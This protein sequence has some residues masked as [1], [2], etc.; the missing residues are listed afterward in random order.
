MKTR[1]ALLIFFLTIYC[2]LPSQ[3][4]SLTQTIKGKVI[5]ADSKEML[6]GIVVTLIGIN[7]KVVTDSI[8]DF[9]ISN[10]PIGILTIEVTGVNYETKLIPGIIVTSGKEIFLEI[11]LNEKIRTLN[12]V[13]IHSE[14]RQNQAANEFASA[15]SRSFSMEESKR[16]PI[17]GFDPGRI[18]QNFAGVSLTE[19]NSNAVIIRGNSPK[20]IAWRIEGVEIPNPNHFGNTGAGGGNIS[21]LSSSMLGKSDFYTGA[22]PPEFGNAL[23]G[24]FD[25]KLRKGNPD[26]KEHS[27]MVG[28]L[29][30]EAASEGPLKK[31]AHSSYLVNFRY[32]TFALLKDVAQIDGVTPDYQDMSFKLFFPAKKGG[33]LSIFGLGGL[34]KQLRE[35]ERFA[36]FFT[37]LFT[38]F[39]VEEKGSVGIAG[40]SHQLFLTKNSY[41]Q[42][43]IAV[44]TDNYRNNTDTLNYRNNYSREAVGKTKFGSINYKFSSTYN[45][46]INSHHTIRSGIIVTRL[47][48]NFTDEQYRPGINSWQYIFD[49]KGHSTFYEGYLQWKWRMG[50]R[51][52]LIQGVHYSI[53]VLNKASSLEPRVSLTYR[54]IRNQ[55]FILAAGLH[56]RPEHLST[57]F[58]GYLKND[59]A[60]ETKFHDLELTKAAHVVLSYQKTFKNFTCKLET[61]YQHLFNVPVEKDTASFFSTINALSIYDL[62]DTDSSLIS[63]G[64]GEN[65]GIDLTIEKPFTKDWH[66]LLTASLLRSTF[67][68][69]S[70]KNFHTKFDRGFQL[71]GLAGKE[72]KVGKNDNRKIAANG[73]V[74]IA[75]GLRESPIDHR[76][77]ELSN[78]IVYEYDKYY[79]QQTRPYSRIDL[80]IS[81]KINR[82]RSTHIIMLDIQNILNHENIVRTSYNFRAKRTQVEHS[83]GL[84][85]LFN[86]RIEF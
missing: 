45:K 34:N 82:S 3:T 12:E 61:Y 6:S 14:N 53:L 70:N 86:Y 48:Y 46:K 38:L 9:R 66:F 10:V 83:L 11:G 84:F 64:K 8:G 18:V 43:T 27:I 49:A 24:V 20:N 81:Y 23:S 80:G 25:L 16:Y 72:W 7:I 78:K 74:M 21:M 59:Q 85:P 73:K 77:S 60:A 15:S 63:S 39:R 40:L 68:T 17:T 42:T 71:V 47:G 32:S 57:Y 41:L 26:K 31:N 51:F 76:Q 4:N 35:P 44:T 28:L 29:G 30:L 62:Y 79:S 58:F 69:Y 37:P 50:T 19:D 75:G 5:D 65:Y 54:G 1:F 2:E 55:R 52:D 13:V 22:F 33:G 67:S 56:S 36:P